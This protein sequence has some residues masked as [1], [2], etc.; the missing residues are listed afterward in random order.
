MRLPNHGGGARI[1]PWSVV[2]AGQAYAL[3]PFYGR[4]SL[5][6]TR[7]VYDISGFFIAGTEIQMFALRCSAIQSRSDTIHSHAAKVIA[8]LH[9]C[10]ARADDQHS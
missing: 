7:N 9:E 8:R 6:R 2:G 10:D 3:A 4:R 5:Y 1:G